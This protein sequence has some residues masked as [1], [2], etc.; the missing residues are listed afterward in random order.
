MIPVSWIVIESNLAIFFKPCTGGDGCICARNASS[1][2]VHLLL[3]RRSIAT[4]QTRRQNL[5]GSC[6][7]TRAQD[8]GL[9]TSIRR[10]TS[11]TLPARTLV[12]Q[13]EWASFGSRLWASRE[14]THVSEEF[15]SGTDYPAGRSRRGL[16][17]DERASPWRRDKLHQL[18]LLLKALMDPRDP[19]ELRSYLVATWRENIHH[20]PLM[21]LLPSRRVMD[22]GRIPFNVCYSGLWGKTVNKWINLRCEMV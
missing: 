13:S 9:E 6:L 8:L 16:R 17:R 14:M 22:W 10:A 5:T 7:I 12:R 3:F 18:L 4:M 19:S 1:S 20:G 11:R 21:R 2:L 15:Y